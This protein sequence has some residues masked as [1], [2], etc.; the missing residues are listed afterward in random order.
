MS[1]IVT[2]ALFAQMG[3]CAESISWLQSRNLSGKTDE[4]ILAVAES[5]GR[6]VWIKW[7]NTKKTT[8]EFVRATGGVFMKQLK[9]FN[10]MTGQYTTVAN[11]RAAKREMVK[12]AEAFLQSCNLT[13]VQAV[14]NEN[15]DSAWVTIDLHKFLKVSVVGG[16][17]D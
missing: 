1:Y 11:V 10:P 3:A 13:A 17:P 2:T 4:E 15:G 14:T 8:G 16:P 12:I 6:V 7:W 5:E 9:I